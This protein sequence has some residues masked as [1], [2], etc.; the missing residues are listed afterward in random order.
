M[1]SGAA[2]VTAVL[3]ASSAQA[4]A[5]VMALLE[6]RCRSTGVD[7]PA[8]VVIADVLLVTSELVTN[9][10]RHGGGL[11]LFT[12]AVEGDALHLRVGD[13][14]PA[15]PVSPPAPTVPAGAPRI[16]GYGWQMVH[17]LAHTVEVTNHSAGK[18]I[19]AVVRLYGDSLDE[20]GP[21]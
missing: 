5:V 1:G 2:E 12:A 8:D 21:P 14:N 17:R 7:W 19:F 3:P 11:T 13:A 4:R 15:H 9:A 10:D 6:S 16:G 18:T 20:G